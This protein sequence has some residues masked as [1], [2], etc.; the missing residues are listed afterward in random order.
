MSISLTDVL[1]DLSEP[2]RQLE[3]A[4]DP[5]AFTSRYELSPDEKAALISRDSN[6]LRV[7]AK[8]IDT[9]DESQQFN[10]LLAAH[11]GK[12]STNTN[13]ELTVDELHVEISV[14]SNEQ[15]AI[16]EPDSLFVDG[17]GRWYRGVLAVGA[18]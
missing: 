6:K 11:A 15:V 14:T 16:A 4:A 8:S 13:M 7:F 5:E 17:E 2:A 1:I 12:N 9:N 10:R 18:S 3:F